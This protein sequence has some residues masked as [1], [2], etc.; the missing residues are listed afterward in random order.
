MAKQKT[1]GAK[2]T[3][4]STPPTGTTVPPS[5]TTTVP[6]APTTTVPQSPPSATLIPQSPTSPGYSSR[7]PTV[8]RPTTVVATPTSD[9]DILNLLAAQEAARAAANR[10]LTSPAPKTGKKPKAQTNA[11]IEAYN[12]IIADL[13]GRQFNTGAFDEQQRYLQAQL[14]Q[15]RQAKLEA[16]QIAA[17]QLSSMLTAGEQRAA[18]VQAGTGTAYNE[19]LSQMLSRGAAG[20]AIGGGQGAALERQLASQQAA[21]LATARELGTLG[22]GN[23]TAAQ[24]LQ[25][26]LSQAASR[27]LAAAQARGT[28]AIAAERAKAQSEFETSLAQQLMQARLGRGQAIE[29]ARQRAAAAAERRAAAAAKAAENAAGPV[30]APEATALGGRMSFVTNTPRWTGQYSKTTTKDGMP[31]TET[32]DTRQLA[33]DVAIL[34]SSIYTVMNDPRVSAA[35]RQVAARQI[36]SNFRKTLDP[37]AREAL[38][39]STDKGGLGLPSNTN[40]WI[41]LSLQQ[42]P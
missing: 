26:I 9:Q 19:A 13:Q 15:A 32:T 14:D 7:T 3:R 33:D 22:A 25:S 8:P 38:T 30:V 11:E 2:R 41:K 5:P 34:S 17:G 24:A 18:D 40:D 1:T 6:P 20:A 31:V 36:V 10:A 16:E 39:A 21:D 37:V 42:A 4:S 28:S 27:D 29:A 35:E 12:K 23:V